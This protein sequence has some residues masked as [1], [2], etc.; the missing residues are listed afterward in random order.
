MENKK[1]LIIMCGVAGSGKSTWVMKHINDFKGTSSYVSRD[2]I[3]FSMIKDG[4]DYFAK[5]NEV[6]KRFINKIKRFL[7]D[8]DNII[9]DATHI[10]PGSRRKLLNALGSSLKDTKIII[11]VIKND[12]ETILKQNNM[13][14]GRAKVPEGT[15]KS[16]C[17]SFIMPTFDEGFDEIWEYGNN[18]Y[19]I[20]KRG[21]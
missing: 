20:R 4:D 9:V 16:M 14:E 3:R 5:E 15:I 7:K 11:V 8:S 6:F 1:Q 13:R 17:K 2:A 12:L 18:R 21:K 19:L 10:T